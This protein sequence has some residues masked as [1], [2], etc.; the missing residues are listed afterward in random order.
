MSRLLWR[1]G[2]IRM[3]EG[4]YLNKGVSLKIG[5][6]LWRNINVVNKNCKNSGTHKLD[7][8]KNQLRSLML[9][10]S[11]KHE[12]LQL[13]YGYCFMKQSNLNHCLSS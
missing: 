8:F 2:K 12:G 5:G 9:E 11:L 10:M 7:L 6:L 4:F 1:A 3:V 13:V